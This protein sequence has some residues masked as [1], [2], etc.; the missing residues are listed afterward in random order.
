MQEP[1]VEKLFKGGLGRTPFS[2]IL[3]RIW[4]SRGTGSLNMHGDKRQTKID[5]CDGHIIVTPDTFASRSFGQKLVALEILDSETLKSKETA[6]KQ[7]NISLIKTLLQDRALPASRLWTH[8]EDY[9]RERLYPLFDWTKGE[10]VFTPADKSDQNQSYLQIHVLDF[11]LQ[12]VRKMRNDSI[13]KA[14]LP[15][16]KGATLLQ[17]FPQHFEEI[18]FQ[19]QETYLIRLLDEKK[20]LT[21]LF[22]ESELGKEESQKILFSLLSLGVITFP[23]KGK[24]IPSP[25]SYSQ[26][27]LKAHLDHLNRKCAYIYK[28]MS[29]E[30]GPVALNVLTKSVDDI[31]DDLSPLFKGIKLLQDGNFE[32]QSILKKQ[33]TPSGRNS[34]RH[35]LRDLN[36]ILAAEVLAV[37]R[38]LGDEM[39]ST[40][41]HNLPK[42]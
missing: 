14:H 42:T 28:F 39:E 13:I 7:N 21:E 38:T 3:H 15:E 16:E 1:H 9:C 19:T 8:L 31:R 37:K 17:L 10:Y 11:I 25:T 34:N 12:G 29:K 41:I 40:L 26:T 22:S 27:D 30:I 4:L 33:M 23:Q 18:P 35:L 32:T 2:F 20:S 5:F 24:S 36:E 6:A